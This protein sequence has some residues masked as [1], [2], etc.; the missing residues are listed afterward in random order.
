MTATRAKRQSCDRGRSGPSVRPVPMQHVIVLAGNRPHGKPVAPSRSRTSRRAGTEHATTASALAAARASLCLCH[1]CRS[2]VGCAV[3]AARDP[4]VVCS[5]QPAA[6]CRRPAA[7][8]IALP[9]GPAPAV[10]AGVERTLLSPE[11]PEVDRA[12]ASIAASLPDL[13]RAGRCLRPGR[14]AQGDPV[15]APSPIRSRR[16]RR[17]RRSHSGIAIVRDAGAGC[18]CHARAAL[19]LN[20]R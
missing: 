16:S 6:G 13:A 7:R 1:G 2:R 17:S 9:C 19:R 8:P 15:S 5:A 14:L 12:A 4:R 11:N 3:A 10:W 20:R 18:C